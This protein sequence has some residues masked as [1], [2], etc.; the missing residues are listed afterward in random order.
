MFRKGIKIVEVG[1]RDGLQNEK[2]ILTL[3]QKK[4][5]FNLITDC[6]LKNIEIGSFVSPKWVPQLHSTDKLINSIPNKIRNNVYLSTLV[7]NLKGMEQAVQSKVDEIVLF[8]SVSDSFNKKNINCTSDEAFG[9]FAQLTDLARQNNIK[10]RGSISCCFECPYE[11]RIYPLS[12]VSTVQ[13]FIDIGVTE[14]DIADTIGTATPMQ[15]DA[16]FNVLLIKWPVDMFACH[17]HDTNS[18]AVLN[19]DQ[20][21]T[22]GITTFHSSIGGLGGCPYSPRR[23]GNL[24][25]IDLVKWADR[26]GVYTGVDIAKLEKNAEIIKKILS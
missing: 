15:I 10:I 2:K 14:I 9:K 6:G 5:I 12:V 7:P 18:S 4:H 17:F 8:V 23:S 26:M 20:S 19:V 3:D 21:F 22:R 1:L 16:L 11:G 25:T 24:N 13:Q